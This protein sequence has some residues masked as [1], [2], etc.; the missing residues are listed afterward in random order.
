[1]RITVTKDN[2]V[3][4]FR[5]L[6]NPSGTSIPY[7]SEIVESVAEAPG[8]D[9]E[10]QTESRYAAKPHTLA[11]RSGPDITRDEKDALYDMLRR[12]LA[13]IKDTYGELHYERLK[14]IFYVRSVGNP[15][16][17]QEYASW[18]EFSVPL[19]S[20]DP[21][22]YRD[23][24]SEVIRPGIA[25]NEGNAKTPVRFEFDGPAINPYVIINEILYQYNGSISDGYMLTVDARDY[26]A[27][28]IS[29]EGGEPV[30]ANIYWNGNFLHLPKGISLVNA[31]SGEEAQTRI[32]WRDRWI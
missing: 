12:H 13:E 8:L 21:Y 31:V 1:M 32:I 19:K 24:E 23:K 15:E 22:V 7:F 30:N 3:F 29:T 9:G 10:I 16:I 2:V 17:S 11:I 28:I 26:S 6:L 14:S 18:I 5:M 4:P 27:R 25:N 20:H